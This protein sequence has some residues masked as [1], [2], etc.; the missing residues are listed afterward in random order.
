MSDP[1]CDYCGHPRSRHFDYRC[2]DCKELN[3]P[4]RVWRHPFDCPP[5]P[6]S[7]ALADLRE[8]R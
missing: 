5:G 7:D 8:D 4:E 3:E 2:H 1:T 6:V